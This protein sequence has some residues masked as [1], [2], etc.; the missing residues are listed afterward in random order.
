MHIE[1]NALEKCVLEHGVHLPIPTIFPQ[2][3]IRKTH[4]CMRTLAERKQE[5]S[6]QHFYR[7]LCHC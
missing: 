5:V 2:G 6:R 1:R 4:S 3:Q 7:F